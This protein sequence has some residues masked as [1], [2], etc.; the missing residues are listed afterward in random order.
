MESEKPGMS[1]ADRNV[2]A[3]A[4]STLTPFAS[5][6]ERRTGNNRQLHWRRRAQTIDQQHD[7][8]SALQLSVGLD[9]V[10]HKRC[11][12]IRRSDLH[13]ADTLLAVNAETDLDLPLAKRKTGFPDSRQG[14]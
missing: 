14:A 7:A 4:R 9:R 6:A 8:I 13:S 1:S 5:S 2:P 12:I 10:Q 3:H 11:Q